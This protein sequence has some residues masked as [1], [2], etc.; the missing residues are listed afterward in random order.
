MSKSQETFTKK[1]KE[2]K[3]HKKRLEKE[4]RKEDRK[5]NSE[6]KKSFEDMLAYVDEN[7]RLTTTP[8][9]PLK[10]KEVKLEDIDINVKKEVVLEDEGPRHGIV[11][12]FNEAKGFG[13]IKEITTGESMFVHVTAL[14]S[15]IK[16]N[17]KVIFEVEQGAKGPNAVNVKLDR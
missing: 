4:Q 9:D 13:F 14:S 8:P 3:R 15:P 12:F 16:E 10:R 2:K 17:D 6:G 1:E 11:S 5:T 7:G